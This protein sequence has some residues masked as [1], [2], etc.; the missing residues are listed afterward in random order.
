VLLSFLGRL[1]AHGVGIG[2][3]VYLRRIIERLI[4]NAHIQAKG[5]SGWD[6]E[7]YSN[8]GGTKERI[9]L[10]KEY[11]P[12]TLVNNKIVYSILS[13]GIHELNENECKRIFPVMKTSIELILDEE[14][15]RVEK[16]RKT[17]F[18]SSQIANLAEEYS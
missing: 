12:E 14:L 16:V 2:A 10:L 8:V 6:E 13:K 3:F 4:E 11:L 17:K 15:A 5:Y 18:I 7:V 1:H 9:T